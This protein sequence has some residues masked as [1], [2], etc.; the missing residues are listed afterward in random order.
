MVTPSSSWKDPAMRVGDDGVTM[1]VDEHFEMHVV[2][3]ILAHEKV[4]NG[5]IILAC[6]DCQAS[7]VLT[8]SQQPKLV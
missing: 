1:M 8:G 2:P 4:D 6:A 3:S 7:W 5:T